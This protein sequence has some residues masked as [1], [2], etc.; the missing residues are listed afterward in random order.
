ML[1]I[2]HRAL[3]LDRYEAY[4]DFAW[5]VDA[6]GSYQPASFIFLSFESFKGLC[7]E[8]G[9]DL[10][11][12]EHLSQQ[13]FG[14]I[15]R[16]EDQKDGNLITKFLSQGK[17][18]ITLFPNEIIA[19]YYPRPPEKER[20]L[21]QA[22]EVAHLLGIQR[23]SERIT[24]A[25]SNHEQIVWEE[26]RTDFNGRLFVASDAWLSD[27]YFMEKYGWT[28]ENAQSLRS[29]AR[30]F[31]LFN[32]KLLR[33]SF[34]NKI[35]FWP[36]HE[37]I[38]FVVEIVNHGLPLERVSIELEISE[39]FEPLSPIERE[40]PALSTSSKSSF[41]FQVIPR[42]DG[43]FLQPFRVKAYSADREEILV[44][45]PE[46]RLE[47]APSMSALRTYTKQDDAA[48][49]KLFSVFEGTDLAE[50]V[51]TL[52]ALAQIDIRAC[53][54]RIRT[55]A[56]KLINLV[57]EKQ[58]ISL[59]RPNFATAIRLAEAHKVLSKRAV[60]YL[61]TIRIV[62]NLAS[63]PSEISLTNGDVRVASF[64]LACVAEEILDKR[65]L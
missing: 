39:G 41:G 10:R 14:L 20:R 31:S 63:H 60:G 50:H 58:G 25:F 37:P 48:F 32:R 5:A 28:E 45:A 7:R 35:A 43:A 30:E 8:Y 44:Y 65:L 38:S 24:G 6:Y 21:Q 40:L 56:E 18:V 11:T 1:P 42:V 62:G 52:P 13:S 16:L 9:L 12:P 47:I 33:V 51:K 49:S 57:L 15:T 27:G 54:N 46:W 53:L 3:Y 19:L 22:I 34:R 29:L 4:K 23:A 64:A 55:V 17:N 36:T 26:I 59:S 61:H 2:E